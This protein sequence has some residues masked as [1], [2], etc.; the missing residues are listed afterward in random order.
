M[1]WG[2]DKNKYN[3]KEFKRWRRETINCKKK[4][5]RRRRTH[6]SHEVKH[7]S[8]QTGEMRKEDWKTELEKLI[9]EE[10][11]S[12]TTE[13]EDERRPETTMNRKK[14]DKKERKTNQKECSSNYLSEGEIEKEGMKT[15]SK[16]E[17]TEERCERRIK[18]MWKEDINRSGNVTKKEKWIKRGKVWKQR[19]N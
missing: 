4:R 7:K 18:T 1:R 2:E 8:W 19:R 16:L 10:W 5:R 11:K 12:K 14:I 17:R 13:E 15:E 9:W 6:D 3:R